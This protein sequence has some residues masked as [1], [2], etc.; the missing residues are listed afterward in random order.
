MLWQGERT[1]PTLISLAATGVFSAARLNEGKE[2]LGHELSSSFRREAERLGLCGNS[3]DVLSTNNLSLD[4]VEWVR[5][6]S[7]I[8]WGVYAWLTYV[9]SSETRSCPD[10]FA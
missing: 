5:A 7:Q 9:T 10:C 1:D 8:A 4:S 6:T 3:A 2:A